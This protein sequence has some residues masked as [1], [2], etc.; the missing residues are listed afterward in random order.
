MPAPF[1]AQA[2]IYGSL[3]FPDFAMG[4]KKIKE[5]GQTFSDNFFKAGS[6]SAGYFQELP[7]V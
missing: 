4:Q 2:F 3:I 5:T 6:D 1:P 7:A